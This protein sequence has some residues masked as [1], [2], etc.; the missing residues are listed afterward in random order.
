MTPLPFRVIPPTRAI[1]RAGF[2]PRTTVR[3]FAG[4]GV[5]MTLDVTDDGTRE[6]VMGV[7]DGM[8]EI[9]VSFDD[10]SD[11]DAGVRC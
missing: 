9:P 3:P 8:F 4:V 2:P 7:A 10:P 1:H 6:R 5:A 11:V